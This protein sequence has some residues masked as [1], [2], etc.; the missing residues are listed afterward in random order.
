MKQPL[1]ITNPIPEFT[2][3]INEHGII[4]DIDGFGP[5]GIEGYGCLVNE[6]AID[7]LPLEDFVT[8]EFCCMV[9]HA[10]D[11]FL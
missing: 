11:K 10:I 4:L 9:N 2:V 1:P 6:I 3:S 8:E 7:E 5:W